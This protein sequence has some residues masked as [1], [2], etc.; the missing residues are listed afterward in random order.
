MTCT[1]DRMCCGECRAATVIVTKVSCSHTVVSW[2]V[3]AQVT[4]MHVACI[5]AYWLACGGQKK[6]RAPMVLRE[7]SHGDAVLGLAWN[8]EYRNVL[9]SACADKTVKASADSC[10]AT[11]LSQQMGPSMFC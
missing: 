8:L 7:G 10:T 4:Y 2:F 3:F 9:A 5:A 6:R 11:I 1:C